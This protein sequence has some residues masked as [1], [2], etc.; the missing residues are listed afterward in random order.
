MG[1][2]QTR[3]VNMG[4]INRGVL[5]TGKKITPLGASPRGAKRASRRGRYQR[6]HALFNNTDNTP[7][8][9]RYP[10]LQGDSG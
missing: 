4:V 10:P 5:S 1:G 8:L 6:Y 7:L 9:S 3:P 2:E